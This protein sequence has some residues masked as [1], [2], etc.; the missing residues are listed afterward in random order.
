MKKVIYLQKIG[1]VNPNIL[2]KLKNNLNEIFNGYIDSIEILTDSLPLIDSCYDSAR[3]KYYSRCLIE[4]LTNHLDK[5]VTKESL[6]GL[7]GIIDKDIY[8]KKGE[9]TYR[10]VFGAALKN[11]AILSIYRLR[12]SYYGRKNNKK[13]FQLRVLK[14]SVHEIGHTF[15]LKH[16][17]NYC[18]MQYSDSLEEVEKKPIE[19]CKSC[20][21]ELELFLKGLNSEVIDN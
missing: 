17:E 5:L 7:L 16:C 2:R 21:K 15:N 4:Q 1:E 14:E 18:V 19:F 3:K 11:V 10:F 6:F 9:I 12:E 13:L 8:S 20:L